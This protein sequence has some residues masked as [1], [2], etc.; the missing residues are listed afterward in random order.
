[1]KEYYKKNRDIYKQK[2]IENGE[3]IR[4]YN[5]E[6][7]KRKKSKKTLITLYKIKLIIKKYN[8]KRQNAS[9]R[10]KTQNYNI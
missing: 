6:Y 7:K 9:N 8:K 2:Y 5:R 3:K 10:V 4:E 1:M